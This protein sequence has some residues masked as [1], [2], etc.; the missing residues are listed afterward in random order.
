[1]D[2]FDGGESGTDFGGQSCKGG[3]VVN[4]V[5]NR[6]CES[7]RSRIR[8]C[9]NEEIRFAPKFRCRESFPRF[10]IFSFQKMIEEIF[11]IDV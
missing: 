9:D 5:K 4:Q 7:R 6:G 3:R 10:R 2:F 8:P 11:P 1:M